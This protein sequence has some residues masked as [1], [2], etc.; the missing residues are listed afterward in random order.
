VLNALVRQ[1]SDLLQFNQTHNVAMLSS[2][3]ETFALQIH[4]TYSFI[5]H[6]FRVK[7]ETWHHFAI[8]QT[9]YFFCRFT[10]VHFDLISNIFLCRFTSITLRMKL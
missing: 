2:K 5:G 10:V 7:V 8:W 9:W 6:S 4:H 3:C 1:T